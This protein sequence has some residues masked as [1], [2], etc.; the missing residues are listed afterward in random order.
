MTISMMTDIGSALDALTADSK[1]I[2]RACVRLLARRNQELAS[3]ITQTHSKY[4]ELAGT[5]NDPARQ[6][7]EALLKRLGVI[8]GVMPPIVVATVPRSSFWAASGPLGERW[9]VVI[10]AGVVSFYRA[11]CTIVFVAREYYDKSPGLEASIE[12]M[13]LILGEQLEFGS[14]DFSGIPHMSQESKPILEHLTQIAYEFFILHEACHITERHQEPG[15]RDTTWYQ[16]AHLRHANEF[17][18]DR[19]AFNTLLASLSNDLHLVAVAIALLFDCLD[20]LDRFDFAAMTRLTHPSP[21]ARKWRLMRLMEAPEAL[22]FLDRAKLQ[23]ARGFSLLYER[24]AAFIVDHA[25]PSTPLNI[26]LNRGAE[27]GVET[28]VQSMLTV[29]ARGDPERVVHNLARVRS[30]M[31]EWAAGG[32]QDDAAWAA[33][34]SECIDALACELD[35]IPR[36]SQLATTL[37]RAAS[38]DAERVTVC[39]AVRADIA[40][41]VSGRE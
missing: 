11:L 1:S 5:A 8:A 40:Q 41:I 23:E 35:T 13:S 37:F 14:V 38:E 18:A 33:K 25:K 9:L 10:P 32:N 20:L 22:E 26:A 39:S 6:S 2:H 12:R 31:Q 36:L 16:E 7:Y 4:F 3:R 34:V 30:S 19:W 24:L 29:L 28:F 17:V 15:A 27:S 21:A